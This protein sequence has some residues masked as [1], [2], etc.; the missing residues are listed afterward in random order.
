MAGLGVHGT[1]LLAVFLPAFLV[2]GEGLLLGGVPRLV[3]A[4]PTGPLGHW[5]GDEMTQPKSHPPFLF[6]QQKPFTS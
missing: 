4:P 1:S 5:T 2:L 6:S 3:E